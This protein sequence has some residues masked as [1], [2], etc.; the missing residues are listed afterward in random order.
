[1][2]KDSMLLLSGP[3]CYCYSVFIRITSVPLKRGRRSEVRG[4]RSEVGG[5]RS[6]VGGRRSEDREW[7][8]ED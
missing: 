4:Q 1:M 3:S 6:E 7:R 2:D 8:I 5:R